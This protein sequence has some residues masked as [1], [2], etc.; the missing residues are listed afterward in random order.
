M[1]EKRPDYSRPAALRVVVEL[2]RQCVLCT[3]WPQNL[4]NV[5][6]SLDVLEGI[7][8]LRTKERLSLQCTRF[9]LA[10]SPKILRL[11]APG[12]Y[13]LTPYLYVACPENLFIYIFFPSAIAIVS[14]WSHFLFY[15]S[16]PK[17]IQ[18][19]LK[20][21]QIPSRFRKSRRVFS[22]VALPPCRSMGSPHIAVTS[23]RRCGPKIWSPGFPWGKWCP[24]LF[25]RLSTQ[26]STRLC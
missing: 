18:T 26:V 4:S 20:L 15:F 6:V 23:L 22:W 25:T 21:H 2:L 8:A 13:F 11:Y 9:P 17:W 10:F 16:N 5:G 19:F 14:S 12:G 24:R 1:Y 3:E 7:V